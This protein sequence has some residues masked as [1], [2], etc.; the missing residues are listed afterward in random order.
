MK[1]IINA[2]IVNGLNKNKIDVL[3]SEN[4]KKILINDKGINKLSELNK[5]TNIIIFKP[6]DVEIFR[7]SPKD[8]RNF[9]DINIS[10]LE[11]LYIKT[12]TH[13]D[14]ILKERNKIL[15]NSTIDYTQLEI[16]TKQLILIQ[17]EIIRMRKE[18]VIKINDVINKIIKQIEDKEKKVLLIYYPF[19]EDGNE[20]ITK[21]NELYKNNLQN[22]LKTK[23]TNIG[24][25][26]EDFIL[27]LD[28][29]N[30][31]ISGSQGENRILSIAL[32]ISPYFL[33]K[34]KNKHP[35]V[36]LDDV[37]SEL[38]Q[39]HQNKLI[40]FLSKLEQVFITSTNLYIKNALIYEIKN[41]QI[42]RRIK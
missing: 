11:D 28:G 27:T 7:G 26:R 12:L 5:I 9:L 24:I 14:V 35:I 30:I 13:F 1:A 23:T 17:K 19:I 31:A 33:V 42:V 18:F 16:I 8:R 39:T 3:I 15:K 6:K 29:D 10:K 20:Y 40:E 34:D 36:A 4:G 22:D 38:D 25:H 37:M 21:A 32:K 2:N 41:H